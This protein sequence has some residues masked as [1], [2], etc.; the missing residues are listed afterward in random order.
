[1]YWL[2]VPKAI[3]CLKVFEEAKKLKNVPPGTITA[4]DIITKATNVR[5]KSFLVIV[6]VFKHNFVLIFVLFI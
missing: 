6:I 3:H 5:H 1:M 2:H 4:L